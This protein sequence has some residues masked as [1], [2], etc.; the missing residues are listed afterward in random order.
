MCKYKTNICVRVYPHV[1]CENVKMWNKDLGY[2][3]LL[4]EYTYTYTYTHT[5]TYTYPI[6]KVHILYSFVSVSR[7]SPHEPLAALLLLE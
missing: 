2:G 3:L 6:T 5:Y 7:A 4:L 1:G